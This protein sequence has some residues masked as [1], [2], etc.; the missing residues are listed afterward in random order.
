MNYIL[1]D[2]SIWENLLPITFTRPVGE[3]KIGILK[4]RQKWEYFLK[5]KCSFSTKNYLS[6]KFVLK[7]TNFNVLIN[8]SILPNKNLVSEI[9]S[10]E[11]NQ[12]LI[13]ENTI[14]AFCVSNF[15]TENILK[16][17]SN[18]EKKNFYDDFF[19]IKNIWEVFEK[20]GQEI[21]NDFRLITKNRKSEEISSTNRI[22]N[23]ENIFLEKGAKLEFSTLNASEGVIYIGKNSQ[24]MEGAMIRGSFAISENSTVKMGAKIYGETSI[25]KGCKIGGEISNVVFFDYSNKAHDGYLGNAIIGSWCNLGADTNNS[26]L[27]NNYSKVKIWKYKEKKFINTNLQFCGLIMADHSKTGINTMLN[28]GT[29]IGVSS[30]IFGGGFPRVFIPSFSWG[31]ANGFV[32]YRINKV[33]EVAEI[34]MKR[35]NKN[36]EEIQEEKEILK[37]IY[38]NVNN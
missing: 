36:E 21:E 9:Q 19:Q 17:I 18:F 26:N 1:F 27:K 2:D 34:V 35:R 32:N 20:N 33:L 22:I 10:L 11:L 3:I 7:K 15:E 30:N 29:V 13:K 24:I 37:K 8:S 23:K 28:T 6:K 14:I 31:G 38:S 4:I 25:G 16:N 12:I 5:E